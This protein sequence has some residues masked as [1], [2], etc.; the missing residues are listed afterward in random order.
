[1]AADIQSK[2]HW[3]FSWRGR[4]ND[5]VGSE[6][7]QDCN[8]R[9]WIRI[10]AASVT[11]CVGAG[12]LMPTFKSEPNWPAAAP[13]ALRASL[14]GWQ[15]KQ[16]DTIE[17]RSRVAVDE[18][19]QFYLRRSHQPAWSGPTG[20]LAQ[21]DQLV[22]A[23]G[24]LSLD[25]LNPEA[26]G[27]STLEATIESVR[28]S[29]GISVERLHRLAQLDLDL[30]F[31]FLQSG[32]HLLTGRVAKHNVDTDWRVSAP[33]G[34]LSG[35]LEMALATNQIYSSLLEL[36][37]R[38]E[39]YAR[40]QHVRQRYLEMAAAGGWSTVPA[41]ISSGRLDRKTA[42]ILRH[43][44]LLSGDNEPEFG[45]GPQ[46]SDEQLH[47]ALRR[48]QQR[49]G[50]QVTGSADSATV[51]ALNVSVGQRI[52]QLELNLER[53]RWLPHTLGSRY[54]LVRIADFELDVVEDEEVELTMRVIVGKPYT[55]TPVFTSALTHL[56]LNPYWRI[57]HSISVNEILPLI[58]RDP[59]YLERN[60]IQA[61]ASIDQGV[62]GDSR[63]EVNLEAVR[64]GKTMLVQSPGRTN[65]LG[66][67]KF[68]LPNPYSIYLHDTPVGGLFD[69]RSRDFSHGCIRLERS[70]DLATYLLGN[71]GDW[72]RAEIERALDSGE[73][74][75]IY[76]SDSVPVF[77]LYWTAWVDD[78]GRAQ[79]R[80]DIYQSDTELNRAL[81]DAGVSM[82]EL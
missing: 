60:G 70:I 18:L 8:R 51:A 43:R 1:M 63:S 54:I 74:V 23:L 80:Q 36:R 49:H 20:P 52:A 19:S 44:L 47:A 50:L 2:K 72:P 76:L 67:L 16:A 55:R 22:E 4:P 25:G 46:T 45:E 33:T 62:S 35:L 37:P 42:A 12:C 40:L 14:T 5:R 11:L 27:L 39:E 17:S 53:W 10:A 7:P 32:R 48:F 59:Y 77:L 9:L 21:A 28:K 58:E 68:V 26:Y 38:R 78:E 15:R 56:V 31:A 34:D 24:E 61:V 79:F 29:H 82:F 73:N 81:L 41:T 57:P 3:P 13:E 6:R 30:T 64:K 69:R 66:R 71:H 65:P 75:Q